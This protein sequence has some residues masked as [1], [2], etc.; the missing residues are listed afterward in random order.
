MEPDHLDVELQTIQQE[1]REGLFS[2]PKSD[3]ALPQYDRCERT[4]WLCLVG[5]VIT[6]ACAVTC[7]IRSSVLL[8]QPV[9]FTVGNSTMRLPLGYVPVNGLTELYSL[10]VTGCLTICMES[11]GF[12]HDVCLRWNLFE[13]HRLQ[14]VTN[15]RLLSVSKKVIATRWHSDALYFITLAIAYTAS[16]QIFVPALFS[17]GATL[18]NSAASLASAAGVMTLGACLVIQV[19]LSTWMYFTSRHNIKT[20]SSSPLTITLACTSSDAQLADAKNNSGYSCLQSAAARLSCGNS[21]I[22]KDQQKTPTPTTPRELQPSLLQTRLVTVRWVKIVIYILLLLLTVWE[23]IVVRDWIQTGS[24][25]SI[26][27]V[28]STAAKISAIQAKGPPPAISLFPWQFQGSIN[29]PVD[30]S[31]TSSICIL[32]VFCIQ[33]YLTFALHCVEVL[34]NSLRDQRAWERAAK[35][36]KS[37]YST[38][39]QRAWGRAAKDHKSSSGGAS[40]ELNIIFSFLTSPPNVV[41]LVIKTL[42]HWL[43]NDSLM[44]ILYLSTS[45][46]G[47][48][49]GKGWQT[50][51]TIIYLFAVPTMF[52]TGAAFVLINFIA[53]LATRLPSRSQPST[54]GHIQTLAELIDDWGEGSR[55]FWGDKGLTNDGRFRHAGTS[56]HGNEVGEIHRDAEYI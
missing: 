19:T 14:W 12:I 36:L 46:D 6:G 4:K 23:I 42:A 49:V 48:S 28:G 7:V 45:M 21:Q 50:S 10:I 13:K 54:Y 51:A 27:E 32:L 8:T 39:D 37:I 55:L 53:Y 40:L 15:L 9:D 1:E 24:S 26:N 30:T 41:L 2:G 35:D 20:W 56:G 16:S 52:L 33:A 43:F 38:R 44:P 3:L 22:L 18:G 29:P 17:T 25:I 47:Q 11:T 34:V 5:L 31:T